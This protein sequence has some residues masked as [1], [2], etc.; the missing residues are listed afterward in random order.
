LAVGRGGAGILGLVGGGIAA[1]FRAL[2]GR[3]KEE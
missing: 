3:R 2:F 1:F